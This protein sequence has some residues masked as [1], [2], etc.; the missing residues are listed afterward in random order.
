MSVWSLLFALV[1]EWV[2]NFSILD[3]TLMSKQRVGHFIFCNPR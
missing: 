1:F 3:K 2:A